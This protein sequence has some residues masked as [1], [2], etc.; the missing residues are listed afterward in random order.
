[1]WGM[2]VISRSAVL[3]TVTVSVC[4]LLTPTP[5]L[6]IAARR[7]FEETFVFREVSVLTLF[8]QESAETIRVGLSL[9]HAEAQKE[10]ATGCHRGLDFLD[11]A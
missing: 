5:E 11:R 9:R 3:F 2:A 10:T 8:R 6:Y 1:M 7:I 4:P